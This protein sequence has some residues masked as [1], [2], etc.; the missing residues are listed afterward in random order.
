MPPAAG[1]PDRFLLQG[2][3]IVKADGCL[4]LEDGTL[5]GADS[6]WTRPFAIVVEQIGSAARRRARHG[7]AR[8]R[9]FLRR[10]HELGR[11]APGYLASLVHLDD[12]LKVRE[13]WVEGR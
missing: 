10:G 6:R 1:G 4:R 2:R 11:L 3:W 7:L 12:A 9:E 5:A 8:A 13:T